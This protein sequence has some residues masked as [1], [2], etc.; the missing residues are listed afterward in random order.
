VSLVTIDGTRAWT[1]PIERAT[2]ALWLS[3][4]ALAIV[5][6]S[7]LVRVEAATGKPTVARCGWG[8]G[9]ATTPHPTPPTIEPVCSQLD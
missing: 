3:D 1:M 7:G 8:F 6:P 9:L 4:G 2:T 5:T